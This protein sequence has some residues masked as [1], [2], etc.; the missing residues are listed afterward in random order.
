LEAQF[1]LNWEDCNFKRPNLIFV[2]SINWNQGKIASQLKF[3][4]QLGV[5]LKKFAAKDKF[6]KG[7]KLWGPNW[8]KSEVKLKKIESLMVNRGSN[9]INLRSMTKLK[10][11]LQLEADFEIQQ[12]QNCIKLE[13][14]R[15]LK[16]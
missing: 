14:W 10:N 7:D 4:G 13:V 16:V 15:K 11:M 3:W 6:K 9:Y 12:R 5:K 2:K 1:K 8:L